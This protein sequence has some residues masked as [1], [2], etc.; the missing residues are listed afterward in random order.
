MKHALDITVINNTL[1][2][3]TWTPVV[4]TLST[5]LTAYGEFI[6]IG[7]VCVISFYF[8]G[9]GAKGYNNA[10]LMV[11]GG[12]PFEP[13]KTGQ[14][15]YAGGGHYQGGIVNTGAHFSGW[16]IQASTGKIHGRTTNRV[17]ATSTTDVLNGEYIYPNDDNTVLGSGTICYRIS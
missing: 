13:C 2:Y 11:I 1:E 5:V 4:H 16:I 6:R 8:E 17:T 12:L 9:Y 14:S 3:G 7:N 15:W 10:G